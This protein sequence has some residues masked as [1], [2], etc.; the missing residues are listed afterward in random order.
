[1]R[2]VRYARY[3]EPPVLVDVPV[4]ACPEGGILVDVRAVG[5]CRSDW[6]A[7]QGH[8]P[9]PLP[10]IGG[11]EFAGVV[12]ESRVRRCRPGDRV[13]VP[14]AI[15][16]GL[17]TCAQC[18]EGDP[19]V[20]PDQHQPGFTYD[21]AFAEVV[22]VPAADT[23]VVALPE[24]LGFVAAAALGCRFA[25]AYRAVKHQGRLT[26]GERVVVLG[27]GGVG[28]SAV[29]I[30]VALGAHVVCVD[31]SAA[32]LAM[33]TA[34]GAVAAIQMDAQRSAGD[35]ASVLLD[36]T[37]GGAHLSI[38]A[39]GSPALLEAGL[40]AL[41]PRGRHVQVGLL[42]GPAADP[43]VPMARIIARELQVLG[44]HGMPV[45]DYAEMLDFVVAID[46]SGLVGEVIDLESAPSA[47]IRL[48]EGSQPAGM[49]VIELS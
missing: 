5:V 38:D 17:A 43:P 10:M 24:S 14:F 32:A 37:D 3:G 45:R 6:H 11:H 18:A 26:A 4:P 44:S 9:V 33:A 22:A 16:C 30:A 36:T 42:L 1:M 35:L 28:L 12:R 41:R 29:R 27:A 31:T 47:L 20:C 40:L 34:S 19:H 13:T 8:D 23:N 7:W 25:T 2:A 48:G 15:G 21:G 39:V 49:T 46:L